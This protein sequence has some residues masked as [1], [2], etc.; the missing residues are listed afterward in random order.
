MRPLLTVNCKFAVDFFARGLHTRT[1][2][3]RLPL[4]QLGFLVTLVIKP[5][6]R[7][8]DSLLRLCRPKYR[9]DAG[10][11]LPACHTVINEAT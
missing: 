8:P 11:P 2:V 6:Q 9:N 10:R 4:R 5:L 1:A 3:A 7:R